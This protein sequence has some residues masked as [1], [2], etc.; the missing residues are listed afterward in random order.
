MLSYSR[1][2]AVMEFSNIISTSRKLFVAHFINF[3]K[4]FNIRQTNV[5]VH[6]LVGATLLSASPTTYFDISS[7]ID[8]LIFNEMI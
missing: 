7:Y 5:V 6:A 4:E 2:E 1:R 3:R 8:T